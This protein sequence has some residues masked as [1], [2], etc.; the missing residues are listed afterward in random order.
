VLADERVKERERAL[1]IR[2]SSAAAREALDKVLN[3]VTLEKQAEVAEE[4]DGIHSVERAKEV[5]SLRRIIEPGSM[6]EELIEELEDM[7]EAEA[8]K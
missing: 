2:P 1:R 4:F 6:R 3:D 7:L 8:R 5:G